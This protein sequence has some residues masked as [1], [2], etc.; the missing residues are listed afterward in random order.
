MENLSINEKAKRYDRLY[1]IFDGT[2]LDGVIDMTVED[3]L[4]SPLPVEE[5]DIVI[6]Y[7]NALEMRIHTSMSWT[8]GDVADMAEEN[9][10]SA[11]NVEKL[12]D[13]CQEG[14][15][16]GLKAF[17]LSNLP[18]YENSEMGVEDWTQLFDWI[19]ELIGLKEVL[20]R[21]IEFRIDNMENIPF[22]IKE[23]FSIVRIDKKT[24]K[25]NF[26]FFN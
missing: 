6:D 5:G 17:S 3:L 2:L 26:M 11:E 24:Y 7:L 18:S 9:G 4:D 25:N 1:E 15:A 23:G 10:I 22:I 20:R 13:L 8:N 21:L 12:C 16:D 19:Y 14:D